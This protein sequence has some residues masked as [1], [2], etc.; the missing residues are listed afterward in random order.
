[1]KT[2]SSCVVPVEI[3]VAIVEEHAV[4]SFMLGVPDVDHKA[5][6]VTAI[7]R[8]SQRNHLKIHITK[9]LNL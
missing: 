9:T 3:V 5:C 8:H 7:I 2:T 6:L 1:M 4:E